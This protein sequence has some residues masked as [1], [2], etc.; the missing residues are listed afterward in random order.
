MAAEAGRGD[1]VK[2]RGMGLIPPDAGLE[3]LGKLLRTNAPQVAVMDAQWGD[4][5]RLLGSRRPALLDGHGRR[6][7]SRTAAESPAAASIMHSASELL[8]AD[9]DDAADRWCASTFATSWPGSSASSRR[10][11]KS[12]SQLSTFGLDSLLALELKNNLK[13]G[14]TS[15]CRWPS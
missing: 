12:I 6:S 11:W 13:A 10:S 2:S 1:A 7:R 5:L 8:A 3:L 9:D 14:S 15:R 4:M